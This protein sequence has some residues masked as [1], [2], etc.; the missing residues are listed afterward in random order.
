MMGFPINKKVKGDKPEDYLNI[1]QQLQVD[2]LKNKNLIGP[3]EPLK[4]YNYLLSLD[5]S[6]T[7]IE[8][9]QLEDNKIKPK[10][11]ITLVDFMIVN[12]DKLSELLGEKF[13]I[14]LAAISYTRSPMAWVTLVSN[15]IEGANSYLIAPD[16]PIAYF[17]G[18]YIDYI[19]LNSGNEGKDSSVE[20]CL[21]MPEEQSKQLNA[22]DFI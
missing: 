4:D 13:Y 19:K 17:R 21:I 20:I 12:N 16:K 6:H 10:E 18:L 3:D 14:S 2:K 11:N 7:D 15:S 8:Y 5:K 9:E 1:F 22:L